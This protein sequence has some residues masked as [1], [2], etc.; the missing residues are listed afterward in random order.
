MS[1]YGMKCTRRYSPGI[2]A[3]VFDLDPPEPTG[4]GAGRKIP[5]EPLELSPLKSSGL[6]ISLK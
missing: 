3:G 5:P 2:E 4:D 6:L 1:H